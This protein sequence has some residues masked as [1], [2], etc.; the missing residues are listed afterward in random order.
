ML[1]STRWNRCQLINHRS[2]WSVA[3]NVI[4]VFRKRS[5]HHRLICFSCLIWKKVSIRKQREKETKSICQFWILVQTSTIRSS[6]QLLIISESSSW[7][8]SF[9][10]S[11]EIENPSPGKFS[12]TIHR[13]IFDWTK[14]SNQQSSNRTWINSRTNHSFATFVGIQNQRNATSQTTGQNFDRSTKSI[15]NFLHRLFELRQE[16]NRR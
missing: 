10:S 16:T 5:C 8:F 1:V 4:E 13:W 7:D 6:L 2:Q 11:V 14:R 9:F 15:R 12:D 3:M